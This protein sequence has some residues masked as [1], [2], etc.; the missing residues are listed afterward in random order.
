MKEQTREDPKIL[1]AAERQMQAWAL[2]AEI[3]D[4]AVSRRFHAPHSRQQKCFLTISREA[5][6]GGS[7]VA[8]IVGQRLSWEV[9]DKNLLD[10]VAERFQVNRNMLDLVDETPSN[11]I[12][13]VL[14][15]WMDSK[16]VPHEMYVSQLSRFILAVAHQANF[17]FVGRGAQFLLP[18]EKVAAVRL[19]ASERFRIKRL[20]HGNNLTENEARRHMQELDR[21]RRDFVQRY[22]HHDVTD[23]HLYDIVINTERFGIE[24]TAEQIVAALCLVRS[25]TV[26]PKTP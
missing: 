23:P 1:A 14:G 20:M 11:W 5:G 16:I 18:R 7:E 25:T 19:V 24:G 12:Y 13:D 3:A 26:E 8:A 4:R 15:T 10:R 9:L 2:N 21:G 17:V 22:F 6:A